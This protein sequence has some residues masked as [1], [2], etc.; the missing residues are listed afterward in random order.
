[1]QKSQYLFI[2]ILATLIVI[3]SFFTFV[4]N[5]KE[6]VRLNKS[7]NNLDKIIKENSDN[8]N[9]L[10]S[11]NDYNENKILKFESRLEVLINANKDFSLVQINELISLA[12]QM[13]LLYGDVNSTIR[14]LIYTNKLLE[15]NLHINYMPLK[16]AILDDIDNLQLIEKVNIYSIT[17]KLNLLSNSINNLPLNIDLDKKNK[18]QFELKVDNIDNPN[19]IQKFWTNL[20]NDMRKLFI[21]SKIN[22]QDEIELLPEKEIIIRQNV[23]LN[24]LNLK[25][26]LLQRNDKL[27]HYYLSDIKSNIDNYF[28]KNDNVGS[29]INIINELNEINITLNY[30]LQKTNDALNLLN[31]K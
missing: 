21:V 15:N 20:K 6:I 19:I 23:K 8:I 22:K 14:I 9:H 12:N 1:M 17:S 18:Y 30:N 28:V 11:I 13:L 2:N 29:L 24:I 27:W 31:N 3:A 16:S 26:T 7:I 4:Y 25:I 10:F 5:Y